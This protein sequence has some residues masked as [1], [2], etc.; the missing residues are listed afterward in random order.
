M[1]WQLHQ[2]DHKQIICT[3]L[4][5]DN[6]TSTLSLNFFTGRMFF[7]TPNQQCQSTEGKI[8]KMYANKEQEFCGFVSF[9]SL[10][11]CQFAVHGGM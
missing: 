2:L 1:G 10:T 4:Q 11:F 6:H 3:L 7:L 8:S 5:T 9:Q